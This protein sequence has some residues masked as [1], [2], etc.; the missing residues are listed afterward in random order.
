LSPNSKNRGRKEKKRT[1]ADPYSA[2]YYSW[3]PKCPA[4]APS[5]AG[6]EGSS[7]RFL[8][9]RT[10]GSRRSPPL[11]IG[12]PPPPGARLPRRRPG[13]RGSPTQPPRDEAGA[14]L[15]PVARSLASP[16]DLEL[17]RR[18]RVVARARSSMTGRES[19]SKPPHSS[20]TISNRAPPPASRAHPPSNRASAPQI[21]LEWR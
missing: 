7:C 5:P 8:L 13:A 18:H 19:S 17:L 1:P 12:P 11:D 16:V 14:A 2:P 15:L 10:D 21:E 20:P 9:S 6:G 4:L 3:A